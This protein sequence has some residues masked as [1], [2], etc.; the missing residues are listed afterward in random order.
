MVT[1]RTWFIFRPP[2]FDLE[3]AL[4]K[5]RLKNRHTFLKQKRLLEA[6]M[7]PVPTVV[8]AALQQPQTTTELSQVEEFQAANSPVIQEDYL[9]YYGSGGESEDDY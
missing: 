2:K 4:H 7:T 1:R 3:T 9:D 8:Q 5:K 6:Y